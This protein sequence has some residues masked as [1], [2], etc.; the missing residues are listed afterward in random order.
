[1]RRGGTTDGGEV[2]D[3]DVGARRN[4]AEVEVG[5]QVREE[6]TGFV[7]RNHEAQRWSGIDRAMKRIE[8][9]WSSVGPKPHGIYELDLMTRG[10]ITERSA[11]EATA[12]SCT[13]KW[14]LPE[15]KPG[16]IRISMAKGR[17]CGGPAA[18]WWMADSGQRTDSGSAGARRLN[19]DGASP[20]READ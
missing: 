16:E 5:V 3:N 2:D 14:P 12:G 13:R 17:V 10:Q 7:W 9:A 11:P 6:W 15:A 18:W 8:Y 20:A 19:R 1:M 4:E